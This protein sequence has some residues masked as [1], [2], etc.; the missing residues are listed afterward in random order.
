MQHTR[1]IV[2][3]VGTGTALGSGP[4]VSAQSSSLYSNTQGTEQPRVSRYADPSARA[5]PQQSELHTEV[6]SYTIAYAKR[7]VP[8]EYAEQDLVTII[9]RESFEAE[10]E[11][12][13]SSEKG[14]NYDGSISN[15]PHLTLGDLLDAQLRP[16][17]SPAVELGIDYSSEFEGEG[18]YGRSDS[19]IGRVQ[20]RIIEV[21]PNGTLVLEARKTLINDDEHSVLVATGICRPE[22]ITA[23]NTVLS[24]VI[25]DLT[26]EKQHEGS[27]RESGRKGLF[28]RILDFLFNF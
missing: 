18:E 12:E 26:V 4:S 24:S 28:T 15:F 22:D 11:A 17:N 14:V 19:M 9:I 5:Q 13:V 27:L 25:Y 20:A 16:G 2:V 6:P 8:R 7:P 23:E 21:K 3:V 1:I 10:L